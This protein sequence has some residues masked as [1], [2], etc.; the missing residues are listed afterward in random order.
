MKPI[1]CM[2]AWFF[3]A[4]FPAA[5]QYYNGQVRIDSAGRSYL[6][7]ITDATR[8]VHAGRF[9]FWYKSG[10]IHRTE[11]GYFGKLLHGSYRI[12]DME[13][14]LVEQGRFRK[15]I[16]KGTWRTWHPNGRLSSRQ[17]F[18]GGRTW[19]ET[20]DTLGTRA[21]KGYLENGLFTGVEYRLAGK[22]KRIVR[23]KNG[24]PAK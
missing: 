9:Y 14:R 1:F 21:S 20:Y 17:R 8:R 7:Q 18:R 16:K 11:S 13:R 6:F 12:T 10:R 3:V 4:Q 22:K 15:G 19:I 5:G 2:L 23:I 24:T